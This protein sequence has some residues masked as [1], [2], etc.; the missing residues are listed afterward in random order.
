MTKIGRNDECLCGSK[1]KFK[2]CC[3]NRDIVL[4]PK[5]KN[6][7]EA[8][9]NILVKTLTDELFQPMR[10]YYIVHDKSQLEICF[11][12]L[13]CMQYHENLNDW[14]IEYTNEAEQLNLKVSPANVPKE[15]QPLII[16]TFYIEHE[17]SLLIDVRSIERAEKMVEFI[18]KHIP[19]NVTEIT[20]A[21]IY[22]QVITVS[23]NT[24][25]SIN[26]ID[27]DDI[28]NQKNIIII[29]PK[30]TMREM[31][32]LAE[33]YENDE[34][35]FEALMKMTQ[36]NVKKPL[37]TVEKFPVYFYEEGIK[38]F[39]TSCQMRQMIAMKHY[40]G[41]ENYSFYD[42]LQELGHKNIN[43]FQIEGGWVKK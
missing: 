33:K 24:K 17:T 38:S 41:E 37:P 8:S 27:Y 22:N 3:L 28:F 7:V 18:N 34:E 5:I 19:K 32:E 31:N 26:N 14:V 1:K 43:K 11:R 4:P 16:A 12:Q 39:A 20:H 2:K 36:D 30:K 42:L 25:E 10:L 35:R 23:S 13:K 15:A 6:N 29:D 9:E 40:F 21:A